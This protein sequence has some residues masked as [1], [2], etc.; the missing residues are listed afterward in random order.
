MKTTNKISKIPPLWAQVS[1]AIEWVTLEF[2][3][4]TNSE[5]VAN[6]SPKVEQS[7]CEREPTND[8][9]SSSSGSIFSKVPNISLCLY[10]ARS[11]PEYSDNLRKFPKFSR[12]RRP[13]RN[14]RQKQKLM[15]W[16]FPLS[17]SQSVKSVSLLAANRMAPTTPT[18]TRSLQLVADWSTL[19][20][21]TCFGRYISLA[22][23]SRSQPGDSQCASMS[24]FAPLCAAVYFPPF[25][26]FPRGVTSFF[27]KFSILFSE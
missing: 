20:G 1:V 12:T 6:A 9:I 25:R 8:V 17:V 18:S 26:A 10:R 24:P 16:I 21:V 22:S 3:T 14:K 4:G 15:N 7:N 2:S 27:S 23:R 19:I 5:L 13:H 11:A